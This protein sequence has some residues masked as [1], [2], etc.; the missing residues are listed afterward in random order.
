MN[1]L[2]QILFFKAC[3]AFSDD[4][5]V[6]LFIVVASIMIMP[7]LQSWFGHDYH[8]AYFTKITLYIYMPCLSFKIIF[9]SYR[10]NICIFYKVCTHV[11]NT[12][13]RTLS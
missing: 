7:R 2:N 3:I 4:F 13:S 10:D 5:M 9:M 6:L 8:Q 1:F 12:L 11:T